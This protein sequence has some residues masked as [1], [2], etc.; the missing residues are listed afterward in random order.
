MS[1][2]TDQLKALH[3]FLDAEGEAI[4]ADPYIDDITKWR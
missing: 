2:L 3:A 4:A 1:G